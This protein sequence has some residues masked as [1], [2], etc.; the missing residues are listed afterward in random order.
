MTAKTS[1]DNYFN[2]FASLVSGISASK[3]AVVRYKTT[4]E[5]SLTV[6]ASTGT[7]SAG[8]YTQRTLV[9]DGEWHVVVFDLQ[10]CENYV[11]GDPLSF[12]RIN[13]CDAVGDSITFDYVMFCDSLG[14]ADYETT[15]NVDSWNVSGTTVQFGGWGAVNG[16]ATTSVAYVVTD[17]AGNET[18]VNCAGWNYN[19]A[20]VT[21]A[22]MGRGFISEGTT[23]FGGDVSANLSAWAGQTVTFSL[24]ATLTNGETVDF[25]TRSIKVF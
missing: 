3:Y 4:T 16:Y 9:N 18:V 24:R 25:Y 21:S 23:G 8:P 5:A 2:N 19:R 11:V 20:D 1:G 14:A 6:L 7:N 12:F 10:K 15:V 22:V 13:C 17:A